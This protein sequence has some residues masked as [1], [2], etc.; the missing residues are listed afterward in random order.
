MYSVIPRRMDVP[1]L[2]PLS[3]VRKGAVCAM[4]LSP[5]PAGS[6]VGSG[7]GDRGKAVAERRKASAAHVR[8]ILDNTP[9]P[10]VAL[11]AG[12]RVR[13]WNPR[14]EETFGW[15]RENALGRELGDLVLLE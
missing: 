1:S 3:G 4:P 13:F 7:M 2:L 10:V 15:S 6:S 12:G 11:D 9:D 5:R 8:S 14:A